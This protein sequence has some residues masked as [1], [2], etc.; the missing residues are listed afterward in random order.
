MKK[1]VSEETLQ[2]LRDYYTA[3]L[4]DYKDV[5]TTQDIVKLT[6]YAKTTV[7]SWCNRNQVRHFYKDRTHYIPKVFLVEFFC[8]LPFRSITTKS[9]WHRKTLH[10]FTVL[11]SKSHL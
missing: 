9:A 10:N 5:L 4:A 8:S 6:G 3:L 2:E 1:E 11:V 7:N